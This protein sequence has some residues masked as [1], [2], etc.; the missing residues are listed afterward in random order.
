MANGTNTVTVHITHMDEDQNL[1]VNIPVT[2]PNLDNFEANEMVAGIVEALA[3]KSREW[4]MAKHKT[5]ANRLK[6]PDR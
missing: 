6:T 1:F 3:A 5:T 2:W 4:N